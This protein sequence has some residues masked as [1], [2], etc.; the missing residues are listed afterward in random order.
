MSAFEQ[1]KGFS[2]SGRALPGYQVGA[3]RAGRSAT[4]ISVEAGLLA[5]H[6]KRP[7]LF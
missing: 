6:G 1:E 5:L 7:F 4:V 2:F 3:V